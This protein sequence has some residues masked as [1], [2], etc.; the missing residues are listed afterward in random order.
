MKK[1]DEGKKRKSW[2]DVFGDFDEEFEEMKER[3][4]KLMEQLTSGAAP[5]D[6]EPMIYG[7]SMRVGPDGKPRIQ[8]FGNAP[9]E[10]EEPSAREPLTDVIEEED[11]VRVV[12]ELPGVEKENIHLHAATKALDIEV[13]DPDHRFSKHLDLPCEVKEDSAKATYKNGVLQIL[14]E[15]SS[16]KRKRKEIKIE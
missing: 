16:A 1:K 8:Q 13:S 10:S 2:D 11:K 14:L 7:F 9:S 4:D 12:V 6:N 3:M 15:R 5:L